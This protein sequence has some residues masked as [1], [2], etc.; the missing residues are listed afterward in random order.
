MKNLITRGAIFFG[1]VGVLV[2]GAAM[3]AS[4]DAIGDAVATLNSGTSYMAPGTT[5]PAPTSYNGSNVA[6]AVMDVNGNSNLDLS[7]IASQIYGQV[8]GKY[9]TVIVVNSD[10]TNNVHYG[11][12]PG[13][14]SE[15]VLPLLGNS[16]GVAALNDQ[17]DAIVNAVSKLS[18]ETTTSTSTQHSFNPAPLIG[19]GGSFLGTI[20]IVAAVFFVIR[21]RAH[22]V[23]AITTHV[24]KQDDLREAMEK[25]GQLSEKHAWLQYPTAPIMASILV[26]LNQ[27]F[28]RLDRKGVENQKAMAAVE[29]AS[30]I[31]KLNDALGTDYYMDIAKNRNLWDRPTERLK[32]VQAAAQAV[33]EQILVNIRQ[34]NSSKDLD[35]RVALESILRSVDQPNA[36]DMLNGG[37]APQASH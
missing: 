1:L 13:A 9:K 12:V 25:L 24:I 31:K 18:N 17:H 14:S 20:L 3:P 29:Y 27:L 34:V 6:V 33:D 5:G 4:A 26:S 8:H 23:R 36:S 37:G 2:L 28:E 7:Q 16:S 19:F 21:R 32:E 35:F 10:A 15:V 30:T 11:V 22:R